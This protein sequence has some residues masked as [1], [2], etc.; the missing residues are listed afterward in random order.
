MFISFF[1]TEFHIAQGNPYLAVELRSL[2][3]G[4]TISLSQSLLSLHITFSQHLWSVGKLHLNLSHDFAGLILIDDDN[5][6]N[7]PHLWSLKSAKST[8]A[9]SSFSSCFFFLSASNIYQ[10]YRNYKRLNLS[11]LTSECFLRKACK[12]LT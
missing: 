2:T 8:V 6:I 10:V 1:E 12:N 11:A 9:F 7:Q 4:V 3:N 5:L